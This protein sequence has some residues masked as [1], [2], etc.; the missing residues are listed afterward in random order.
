MNLHILLSENQ[1]DVYMHRHK[2]FENNV[3]FMQLFIQPV[4]AEHHWH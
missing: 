3:L 4:F 1:N 2:Y